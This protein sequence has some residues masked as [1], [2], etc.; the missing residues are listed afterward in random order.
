MTWR[1]AAGAIAGAFALAAAVVAGIAAS[2]LRELV[3][4]AANPRIFWVAPGET[5]LP[6]AQRLDAAGLLPS[7]TL[8]GPRVLVIY[9]QFS[10]ED[11][12]IKSGEYDLSAAM[13]PLQILD[14][15]VQGAVKMHEVTLPEGMRLD[16]IAIRLADAGVTDA[17]AFLALAHDA[18][19]ARSL[20]LETASFEGYAYPETY[21]FRR[22]TPPEEVLE[23]MLAEFRSRF[24][25]E[26][27]AAVKKSDLSLHQIVT[28]ASIVEK[29]SAQVYERP[30]ISGVYQNR[31]RLGMRLQSDPTVIYGIVQTRGFF[32]GDIRSR[33][34][35]E[36]NVWNTY[37]HS[38]LPP[39]PIASPS[40]EAIRA[41]LFPADVP[42]LYFV[43][44]N[45]GSHQFSASLRDHNSAVKLYQ[46][47][48][49]SDLARSENGERR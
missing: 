33:D 43:A 34:L 10:G 4:P 27:L 39:G 29:E 37:T 1:S 42:Y 48:R 17:A 3:D 31:L 36:D 28:L 5:L 47:N 41:V 9:A 11:R 2:G 46:S 18:G 35:R 7:H 13:T 49:R 25:S 32:D 26:D 14:K 23:R 30:L 12:E 21:R 22:H 24:T 8:F 16:E 20:G 45:D 6:I 19:F 38:G 44:R 15:I 40:I